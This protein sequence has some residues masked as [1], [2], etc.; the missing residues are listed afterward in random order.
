LVRQKDFREFFPLELRPLATLTLE[1]RTLL[2]RQLAKA[3]SPA[4]ARLLFLSLDEEPIGGN[5]A[6]RLVIPSASAAT[7][8]IRRPSRTPATRKARRRKPR[9]NLLADFFQSFD[10]LVG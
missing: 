9:P 3:A 4:A 8:T 7:L 1:F 10:L 6:Q 5:I 2:F